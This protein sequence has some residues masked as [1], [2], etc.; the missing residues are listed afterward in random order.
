MFK[1]IHK[2]SPYVDQSRVYLRL[3]RRKINYRFMYKVVYS[4]DNTI[5]CKYQDESLMF[6]YILGCKYWYK[7]EK[8]ITNIINSKMETN[9]NVLYRK[10]DLAT[11]IHSN[12]SKIW[13]FR[14]KIHRENA[15]AIIC[16]NGN[17][18]WYK[19]GEI[20]RQSLYDSFMNIL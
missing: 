4:E 14:G 1:Y 3:N 17:K 10:K 15:P 18:Y 16:L 13:Y 11:F 6:S 2:V 8:Y 20:F 5:L 19:N 12:G 7:Y 9:F